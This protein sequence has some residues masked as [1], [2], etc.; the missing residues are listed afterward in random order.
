MYLEK[1]FLI[2]D[3][4]IDN[5]DYFAFSVFLPGNTNQINL[6]TDFEIVLYPSDCLSDEVKKL[7]KPIN[8]DKLLM[9]C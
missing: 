5:E 3:S 9:Y 6:N 1:E 4:M 8:W 7:L 2:V